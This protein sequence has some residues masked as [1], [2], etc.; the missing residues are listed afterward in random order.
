MIFSPL[1]PD[2]ESQRD[3]VAKEA[4]S[5]KLYIKCLIIRNLLYIKN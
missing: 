5:R 3:T 1:T 4:V 2:A